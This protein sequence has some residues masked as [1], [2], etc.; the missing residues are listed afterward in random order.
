M[1][2]GTPATDGTSPVSGGSA[3]TLLATLGVIVGAH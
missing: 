1:M 3:A 2:R